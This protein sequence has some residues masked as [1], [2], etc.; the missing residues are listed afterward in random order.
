MPGHFVFE[1][2]LRKRVVEADSVEKLFVTYKGFGAR[3]ASTERAQKVNVDSAATD[4][5]DAELRPPFWILADV[6][7][8]SAGAAKNRNIDMR[9]PFSALLPGCGLIDLSTHGAFPL[10]Q[11]DMSLYKNEIEQFVADGHEAQR[12]HVESHLDEHH[13]VLVQKVAFDQYRYLLCLTKPMEKGQTIALAFPSVNTALNSR[14]YR[15]SDFE[16]MHLIDECA[17]MLRLDDLRA[18]LIWLRDYVLPSTR[19]SDSVEDD[20]AFTRACG[21]RRRVYWVARRVVAAIGNRQ[22]P[23]DAEVVRSLYFGCETRKNVEEWSKFTDQQHTEFTSAVS[24]QLEV[25]MLYAMELDRACGTTQRSE[26]CSKA[27]DLFKSVVKVSALAHASPSDSGIKWSRLASLL[28]NTIRPDDFSN[29]EMLDEFVVH[30]SMNAREECSGMF[31]SLAQ[32][33]D[34]GHTEEVAPDSPKPQD[35]PSPLQQPTVACIGESTTTGSSLVVMRRPQD[36][37][38]GIMTLSAE[39]YRDLFWQIVSSSIESLVSNLDS[40]ETDHRD[41]AKILANVRRFVVDSPVKDPR[42]I[43]YRQKLTVVATQRI[44]DYVPSSY[45]FFLGLVWPALRDHKWRM[46]VGASPSEVSF[47]PKALGKA[48]PGTIAQ[49]RDRKSARSA[50]A[51]SLMGLVAASKTAKRLLVA[52]SESNASTDETMESSDAA[53]DPERTVKAVVDQFRSWLTAKF[54]DDDD[55]SKVYAGAKINQVVHCIQDCFDECAPMFS[56][57]PGL[58]PRPEEGRR[59]TEAHQCEYLMQFLL[60]LPCALRDADLKKKDMNDCIDVVQ[61]L[62]SYVA[63][64]HRDIFDKRFHPPKEEYIETGQVQSLLEQKIR[65]LLANGDGPPTEGVEDANVVA[66]TELVLETD[67]SGLTDYLTLVME[68]AVPFWATEE[69]VLKKNGRVQLGAQG[70]M[71]GHCMG[72]DNEGRYFF[73]SLESLSTSYSVLEKHYY[74]CRHTPADVRS[75]VAEARTR[76]AAQ[77]KTTA[78]GA[79]QAYFTRLWGRLRAAAGAGGASPGVG[80][81]GFAHEPS[82]ELDLVFADHVALLDH[83]RGS[84]KLKNKEDLQEALDRYYSCLEYAG[85]I[86]ATDS[87]PNHFSANWLLS[88]VLP[89]VRHNHSQRPVG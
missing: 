78:T 40:N 26:W 75:R 39:W 8:V 65:F 34:N 49:L 20:V 67:K 59:P 41:H 15:C 64:H 42:P 88:K 2:S 87:M 6:Q 60:L 57:I 48:R 13:N 35:T 56:T 11:Q 36:V 1:L 74:K 63:E 25:E 71:C 53:Y 89:K 17:R 29:I 10:V 45:E 81:A 66:V 68:R 55:F 23:E 82:D 50:D 54:A 77:R 12:S 58:P 30:L 70:I 9:S 79:Q 16:A 43:A 72:C 7:V 76:H 80:Y 85:R 14:N 84:A 4:S 21:R 86:Y 5:D 44:V 32:S 51:E 33:M 3:A 19:Y 73:S 61:D 18:L 46:V 62:L 31:E 69:D 24:A 27:R 52:I 47:Y 22:S 37:R 38:D 83:V 28:E